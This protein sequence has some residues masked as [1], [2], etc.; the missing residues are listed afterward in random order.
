[1]AN[2]VSVFF[3]EYIMLLEKINIFLLTPKT[4]VPF[5]GYL[6]GGCA[7]NGLVGLLTGYLCSSFTCI[8]GNIY[9]EVSAD[10]GYPD[11]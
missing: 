5:V 11:G 7:T 4:G 8:I 3:P 6:A 1:M 9:F 10:C 2:I